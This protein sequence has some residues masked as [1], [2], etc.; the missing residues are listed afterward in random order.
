MNLFQALILGIVQGITE[1]LPISSSAH[2]V[3]VPFLFGWDKTIPAEQNFPFGVLV[4][5]GTLL[6]VIVYFW[7]DLVAILKAWFTGLIQRR[8]FESVDARLGWYI[9]LA[10]IP[11]GILGLLFENQ[12]EA[13]F[14]SPA[15]TGLFL[16]VTAVF[17]LAAEI[18]GKGKRTLTQ[19]GWLDALIMGFFQAL[20]IFPGVSR[21][22]STITGGMLRGLD[23]PTAA[24]FSFIM[25]IPIMLAAGLLSIKDLSGLATLQ[26]FLPSLLV[27]FIAAAVFGFLSIRWLLNFLRTRSLIGF[28]VYCALVG[29]LT[30]IINYA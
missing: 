24:R 27:G 18:F 17:L 4:Q 9:I 13:A 15:S 1:F 30:L 3:L 29:I 14:N 23:R 5:L 19:I 26:S 28:S 8:P 12:V 11:A 22:G 25:S 16:L 21:S 10:T 20:A 2:L 7:K 6:A